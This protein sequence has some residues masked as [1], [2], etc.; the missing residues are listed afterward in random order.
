MFVN[1]SSAHKLL[2]EPTK[3]CHTAVICKKSKMQKINVSALQVLDGGASA[4]PHFSTP[5]FDIITRNYYT[6]LCTIH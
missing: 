3:L 5:G 6:K 1:V 2:V 4:R